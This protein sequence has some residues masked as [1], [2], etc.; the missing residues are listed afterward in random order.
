MLAEEFSFQGHEVT[1]ITGTPCREKDEFP[2]VVVRR[3]ERWQLFRLVR[4]CDVY[5]QNHISL[6]MAW[7]VLCAPRPW[8]VASH[9]WI[10][11]SGIGGR[12][13]HF[14]TRFARC[15][16]CSKAVAS[17]LGVPSTVISGPYDNLVFRIMPELPRNGN[18]IFVG[19]L[20][21]D[22]G[23]FLL[24]EAMTKLNARGIYPTLT[25]VGSGPESDALIQQVKALGLGEQILMVGPKGPAEIAK[26]LNRH[27]ILV[28]PSVW[29]EPFG[30]VALEG[31]AC[32]CVVVGS[33][34]GGLKDAIGPCGI[35][36]PNGDAAALASCLARLLREPDAWTRHRADAVSHLQQYTRAAVASSYLKVLSSRYDPIRA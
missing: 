20:I 14:M 1:V 5:L 29:Q 31:I 26:L 19:R 35:T 18:L 13:K 25:I 9:T 32:G 24:L 30:V 12:M 15:I 28:A 21:K 16:S 33:D 2:F 7:P 3:P 27:Q 10:P 17:H 6:K 36:F 11:R 23:V 34:G 8:V 22:K 4:A